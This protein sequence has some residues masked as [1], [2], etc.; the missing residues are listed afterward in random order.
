MHRVCNLLEDVFRE[1]LMLNFD[2]VDSRHEG[3]V[4][5]TLA[6]NLADEPPVCIM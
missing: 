3:G 1:C 5:I 6:D 2:K 4:R